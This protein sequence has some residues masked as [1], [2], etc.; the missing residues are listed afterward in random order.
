MMMNGYFPSPI[1]FRLRW[2]FIFGS[3]HPIL[4]TIVTVTE[5]KMVETM[6]QLDVNML[7]HDYTLKPCFFKAP[8]KSQHSGGC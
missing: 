4:E 5:T 2:Y 1:C 3:S 6:V 8:R 7:A